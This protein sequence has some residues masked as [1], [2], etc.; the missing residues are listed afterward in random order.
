ME[1]TGATTAALLLATESGA[2]KLYSRSTDGTTGSVPMHFLTA[3]TERITILGGGNVGIGTTNPTEKLQVAGI[4]HSTTGGI[5]FPDGT[6][7]STAVTG[8]GTIG[9]GWIDEGATVR[10]FTSSDKV[11][12]GTGVPGSELEVSGQ[13]KISSGINDKIVFAGTQADPHTIYL[14]NSKGIR[15]W[16]NANEELMRITNT[17]NVGIGTTNPATKL[18]VIGPLRMAPLSGNP[19]TCDAAKKGTIYFDN[20]ANKMYICNGG[21]WSDYTGPTGPTGATGATGAQGPQGQQGLTGPTG[22]TG[23][24]GAQGP[25]G[26]TGPQGPQGPTGASPFGLNGNDAYYTQGNVGIGTASPDWTLTVAGNL[27]VTASMWVGGSNVYFPGLGPGGG[28]LLRRDPGGW[29]M[30][31][32]SS[33]KKFKTNIADYNLDVGKIAQ[34]KPVTFTWNNKSGTPGLNDFGLIAEEVYP[35]MPELVGLDN[36]SQPLSIHYDKLGIVLLKGYQ[37]LEKENLDQSEKI[38]NLESELAQF[39][40]E[41]DEM[42]KEKDEN[43]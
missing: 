28:T 37:E 18:D 39:K 32:D 22:A 7:Q 3:D 16:D 6:V 24:T 2:T 42:K 8:G 1:R 40:N 21:S 14:D 9:G 19:F 36:E 35:I 38:N 12:I 43:D 11:G 5:K 31:V 34:L 25:Q 26:N 33:S 10:L 23:A 4:V 17:G 29:L 15:F 20:S 30:V 13:L 41:L 27:H